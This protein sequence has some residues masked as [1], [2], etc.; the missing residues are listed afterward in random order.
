VFFRLFCTAPLPPFSRHAGRQQTKL[1]TIG[2]KG[3]PVVT[4]DHIFHFALLFLVLR[5]PPFEKDAAA[6]GG[7]GSDGEANDPNDPEIVVVL[8]TSGSPPPSP[9]FLPIF[10]ST[11]SPSPSPSFIPLYPSFPTC[12]LSLLPPSPLAG[13]YRLLKDGTFA[14]PAR[15]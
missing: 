7:H 2:A 12:L 5:V 14:S 4:W 15:S 13:K 3:H 8:M 11:P 6:G 1:D 9:L 10:L